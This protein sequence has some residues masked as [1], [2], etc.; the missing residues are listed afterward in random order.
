[1]TSHNVL[2][3]GA[4]PIGAMAA[5]SPAAGLE[6]LRLEINDYRREM[7]GKMGADVLINPAKENLVEKVMDSPVERESTTSSR[8]PAPNRPSRMG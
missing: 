6:G 8:C 1:M 5:G 3:T 2:I 7:A 4:G